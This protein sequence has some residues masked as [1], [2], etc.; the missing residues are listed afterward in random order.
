MEKMYLFTM[1][2]F[3]LSNSLG[4]DSPTAAD[5]NHDIKGRWLLRSISGGFG[6]TTEIV[7]SNDE[8]TIVSY[9]ADQVATTIHNDT[10]LWSNTFRIEK[11]K[12]IYFSEPKDFIV[13]EKQF[14]PEVVLYVTRDTLIL[15]DNM[16]DGFSR[17]FS[18]LQ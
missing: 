17:I 18:R 10:L 16:Y 9:N 11:R 3:L 13:Y 2:A 6:G 12:S 15:G 8:W 1:V 4:C 5:G 7:D 14:D